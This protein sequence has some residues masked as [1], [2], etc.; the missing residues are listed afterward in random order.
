MSI[1]SICRYIFITIFSAL[2]LVTPTRV[3]AQAVDTV[4]V[5]STEHKVR[6][7]DSSGHQLCVGADIFHPILNS[8]VTN[9]KGYEIEADYYM[10]NEFYLVAEGG[11]GES[12]VDFIDLKYKTTNNFLRLGFNKAMATRENKR[13]W[14]MM[15]FGLRIG[16][17]NISRGPASYTV[18]DS[19]WGNSPGSQ[20][21]KNFPAFW[22]ELTAGMR[23]EFARGLFAGWNLRGKFMMNGK[24]FKDLSPLYI[25]GYG[26]G[27]KNAVFDF[28]VYISY[29]IRWKRKSLSNGSITK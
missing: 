27:D 16:A 6:K 1:Q 28:N 9:K 24:S 10:R 17:A 2:A 14:D 15:L 8:F 19:V 22:A 18:I 23:V 3:S 25:A 13:D 12:T 11:W 21:G 7:T 29:G 4:V 20:P 5:D 26:E